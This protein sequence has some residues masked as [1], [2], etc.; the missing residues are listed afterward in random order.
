ML[1]LSLTLLL[2]VGC[3]HSL[4]Y[5]HLPVV[6]GLIFCIS[7]T[8]HLGT[9]FPLFHVL[10]SVPIPVQVAG[11]QYS[12]YLVP[13]NL[14]GV[15]DHETREWNGIVRET[16]PFAQHAGTLYYLYNT[17]ATFRNNCPPSSLR[18]GSSCEQRIDR[19]EGRHRGGSDDHQLCQV[20][21]Y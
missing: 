5:L 19:Q 13:D 3:P 20:L 10:G 21:V 6:E 12:L 11:F 2:L 15:Y 1:L 7:A 14:Y 4:V 16:R 18:N 17:L 8:P 9:S